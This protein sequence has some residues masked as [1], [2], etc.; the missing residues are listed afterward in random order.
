MLE[1]DRYLITVSDGSRQAVGDIMPLL[2]SVS[3]YP[4]GMY[5]YIDQEGTEAR[6][7][8]AG[9]PKVFPKDPSFARAWD[10]SL[11]GHT[12]EFMK[13]RNNCRIRCCDGDLCEVPA[14]FFSN[15]FPEGL[16]YI[17]EIGSK[18]SWLPR[19]EFDRKYKLNPIAG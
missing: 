17:I 19:D 16:F 15:G 8:L 12:T 18:K 3:S 1:N 13:D 2:S 5:R 10:Y 14:D 11:D 6:A 9:L 4:G 7:A